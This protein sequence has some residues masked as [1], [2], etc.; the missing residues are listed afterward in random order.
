MAEK[1]LTIRFFQPSWFLI[2]HSG[3]VVYIDPSYMKKY[4]THYPGKV[5]FFTWPDP[6]DGLPEPDLPKT[7][8]I[9]ITHHHQDHCRAATIRRL[10]RE[11]TVIAAPAVCRE[12]L[13]EFGDMVSYVQPGGSV[14]MGDIMAEA[15]FA[16]N[17]QAGSSTKKIHEKGECLGWLLHVGGRTIYHAG[18]TDFIPEMKELGQVDL[19]LLPVGGTYTMDLDE[20]VQAAAAINPEVVIPMHD[21]GAD[22]DTFKRKVGLNCQSEPV[23]LKTGGSHCL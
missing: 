2:Q 8:L 9:L 4:F 7:D 5:E 20:A 1:Q 23:L 18:D 22:L 3:S 15:V 14:E 21:L 19:A 13:G 16:Y 17:T 10:V 6:I 12:K 11:D